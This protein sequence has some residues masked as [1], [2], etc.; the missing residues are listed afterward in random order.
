MSK[1]IAVWGSSGAGKSTVAGLLSL[2]LSK[3]KKNVIL[4]D[5]CISTPQL[6]VWRP[7]EEI[8]YSRSINSLMREDNLSLEAFSHRLILINDY[9][10][11]LGFVRGETAIGSRSNQREDKIMQ[12][13]EYASSMT[14]YVIIDCNTNFL[15]DIYTIK[16]LELAD[17]VL[18]VISP[19]IKGTIFEQS[20]LSMLSNPKFRATEHIRIGGCCKSFHSVSLIEGII[21]KFDILLPYCE[22][23]ELMGVLGK[24]LE[25]FSSKAYGEYKARLLDAVAV[26]E[27]S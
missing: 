14:D 5:T 13:I 3:Q 2:F 26:K 20:S 10:S 8:P 23:I 1:L 17:T 4:I 6:S 19:D 7:Y 21:G 15:D 9:L 11:I 18:R 12:I 16:A 22:D 25:P 27:V 24:L